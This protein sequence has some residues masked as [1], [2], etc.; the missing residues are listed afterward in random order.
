MGLLHQVSLRLLIGTL[1]R[2]LAFLEQGAHLL[3]GLFGLLR[4]SLRVGGTASNGLLERCRR[5]PTVSNTLIPLF[6]VGR[7]SDFLLVVIL[8]SGWARLLENFVHAVLV[9]F[10]EFRAQ[11][12]LIFTDSLILN[13]LIRGMRLQLLLL[14]DLNHIFDR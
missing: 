6:R 14:I 9:V 3:G 4:G 8:R 13:T 2:I 7:V 11:E 10:S 1:D 12:L 5:W